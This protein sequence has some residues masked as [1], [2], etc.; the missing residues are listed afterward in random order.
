MTKQTAKQTVSSVQV[1][2]VTPIGT[3]ISQ[4]PGVTPIGTIISQVPEK[5][6]TTQKKNNALSHFPNGIGP[7]HPAMIQPGML[8]RCKAPVGTCHQRTNNNNQQSWRPG[9]WWRQ[10]QTGGLPMFGSRQGPAHR[11]NCYLCI[12]MDPPDPRA[13]TL[14]HLSCSFSIH[15]KRKKKISDAD[16]PNKKKRWWVDACYNDYH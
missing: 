15:E 13:S 12:E 7:H 11:K 14:A 5:K 8:A 1:P 10:L 16:E 9:L 6:T 4:V 3:I 2:G